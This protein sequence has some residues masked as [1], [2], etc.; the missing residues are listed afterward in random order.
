MMF[1][2]QGA[3]ANTWSCDG[4]NL[5][6]LTSL[7]MCLRAQFTQVFWWVSCLDEADVQKCWTSQI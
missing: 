5:P 6:P 4:E 7:H 2:E 1:R 3:K